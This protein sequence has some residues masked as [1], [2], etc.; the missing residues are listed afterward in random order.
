MSAE[1]KKLSPGRIVAIVIAVLVLVPILLLVIGFWPRSIHDLEAVANK[2]Q[3]GEGWVLES[4]HSNPRMFICIVAACVRLF[5][6]WRLEKNSTSDEFIAVVKNSGWGYMLKD[7][8][9]CE[10]P[11]NATSSTGFTLCEAKG[12]VDNRQVWIIANGSYNDD[13]EAK[14][15]VWVWDYIESE[16]SGFQIIEATDL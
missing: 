13:T 6:T 10:A 1:R 7:G 12:I 16:E 3:P 5:R 2:F 11:S 4:D 8:M 15:F 9:Q 14:V